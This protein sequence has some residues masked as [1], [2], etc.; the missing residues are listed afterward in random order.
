VPHWYD[1]AEDLIRDDE[2]D[3]IYIATPPAF[4][5]EYAVAAA[6]AAKPVYVEKPMARNYQECLDMLDA[7]DRAG[8]PLFVAYY[9]RALPRFL[10]VKELLEQGA[11]GDIRFIAT[12]QTAPLERH[13]K[14][15]LPWRLNPEL[16]GGGLF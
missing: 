4:H 5:K 11:I 13:N 1:C 2:V 9:R 7:C 3:A 6:R 14:E 12:R 16:S 15:E 10:K 8:V